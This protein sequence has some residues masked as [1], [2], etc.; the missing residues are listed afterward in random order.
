MLG[1]TEVQSRTV[2]RDLTEGVGFRNWT[3]ELV[4]TVREREKGNGL[5][6]CGLHKTA[7][8]SSSF[9]VSRFGMGR[10]EGIWGESRSMVD[11]ADAL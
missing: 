9:K 7:S 5:R 8:R 11:K 6:S 4:A 2:S 3:D 1:G 10:N